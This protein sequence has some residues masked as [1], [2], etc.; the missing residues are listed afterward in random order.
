MSLAF[1]LLLMA[2]LAAAASPNPKL[3]RYY[4]LAELLGNLSLA[5]SPWSYDSDNYLILCIVVL[6]PIRLLAMMLAFKGVGALGLLAG[7][8]CLHLAITGASRSF[9]TSDWF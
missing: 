2:N 1:M 6:V 9:S 4:F 3:Y 8:G 5:L 7:V